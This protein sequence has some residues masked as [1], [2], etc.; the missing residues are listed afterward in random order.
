MQNLDRVR[1]V[2]RPITVRILRIVLGG[3]GRA[4][5]RVALSQD[6][7]R[8][9][10]LRKR[11]HDFESLLN[12]GELAA[13]PHLHVIGLPLRRSLGMNA[14]EVEMRSNPAV[15]IIFLVRAMLKECPENGGGS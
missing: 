11:C 1:A 15:R 2:K 9:P 3:T 7:R 14:D 8:L 10:P 5:L 4:T 13:N 6:D 12:C